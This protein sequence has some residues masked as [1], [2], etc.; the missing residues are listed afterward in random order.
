MDNQRTNKVQ[1]NFRNKEDCQWEECVI[2][3]M[4]STK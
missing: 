1:C 2:T 4:W 3:K